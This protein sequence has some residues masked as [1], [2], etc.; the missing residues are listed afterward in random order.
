MHVHDELD[1][2]V[3]IGGGVRGDAIGLAAEQRDEDFALGRWQ[4][5]RVFDNDVDGIVAER[6]EVVRLPIVACPGVSSGS[7]ACCQA[8]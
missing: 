3:R 5:G 4:P 2:P 7:K 8:A 1:V 6:G